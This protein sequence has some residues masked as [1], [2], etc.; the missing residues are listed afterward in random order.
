[1]NLGLYPLGMR[2]CS[3]DNLIFWIA[4]CMNGRVRCRLH[5]RIRC[6]SRLMAQ[7][8]PQDGISLIKAQEGERKWLT[9]RQCEAAVTL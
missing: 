7:V 1:M 5:S 4:V 8:R 3:L 2:A 6:C 9:R